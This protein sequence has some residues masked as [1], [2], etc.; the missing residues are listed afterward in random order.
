MGTGFTKVTVAL[1]NGCPVHCDQ[2]NAGF[3]ILIMFNCSRSGDRL[4]GG[5]H[6]ILS[7]ADGEDGC[8]V[9]VRDYKWGVVIAGEYS[10]VLHASASVRSGERLAITAYCGAQILRKFFARDY[11]RRCQRAIRSCGRARA[12][13]LAPWS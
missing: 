3:T 9:V 1:C 7:N 8:A 6:V 12:S 2:K 11:G 4:V 13:A 10:K 5:S